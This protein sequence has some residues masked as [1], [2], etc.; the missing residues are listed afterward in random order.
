MHF[1][2]LFCPLSKTRGEAANVNHKVMIET[3]GLNEQTYQN[4]LKFPKVIE[5]TN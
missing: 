2:D 1:P 4:P 5:I 3:F